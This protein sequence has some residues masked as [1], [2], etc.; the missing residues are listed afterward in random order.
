M[1]ITDEK[2]FRIS[3]LKERLEALE[4][5]ALTINA[6]KEAEKEYKEQL[7]ALKEDYNSFLSEEETVDICKMFKAVSL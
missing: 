3:V 7:R 5:L 4:G 6:G 1:K 2:L